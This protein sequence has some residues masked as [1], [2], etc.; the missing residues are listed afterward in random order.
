MKK[1]YLDNAATT[2]LD[3]RVMAEMM[4]YLGERFGNPSSFH[5]VGKEAQNAVEAARRSAAGFLNCRPREIIFCSGGTESD[6][7]AVLGAARANRAAGNHLVASAIEHHAVLEPMHHLR[8]KEGFRVTEAGVD[9][10]G[11]VDPDEVERLITKN[12][13][14]VSVM[15]ANN[16]IGT[17]Q[18]IAEI[19]KR[20]LKWRKA[21]GTGYPLFHTDACQAAGAVDLNVEKL[22]VDFLTLNGSKVYG[23]K[24]AGLLYTRAGA[25][26]ESLTFGGG[27]EA[28]R[29]PGTENVS[30]IVGLAKA[31]EIASA[32][33]ARENKRLVALRD[34]FIKKVLKIIP[35]AYL[36]GHATERLPNNINFSFLNAEGEAMILYLDAKGVSVSSGSAC[37]SRSLDPSHVI[38]ACGAPHEVAHSS[39]RF[40]LGRETKKADLD[41]VLKILPSVVQKIRSMS[42]TKFIYEKK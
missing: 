34:Y 3:R 2:R 31:L 18:P 33:R 8:E 35:D 27:Q 17:I 7:M 21:H 11:I 5:S 28:G 38:L 1:I 25:K 29:R 24:G 37:T 19:G 30:A 42:P 16:E 14:L 41:Y 15:A 20:I 26:F 13:I 32:G 40:T 39:V 36:N 12:T 22:H 4:P 23:P 6:N 10:F 9:K